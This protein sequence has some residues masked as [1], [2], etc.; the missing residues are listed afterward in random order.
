MHLREPIAYRLWDLVLVVGFPVVAFY[1]PLQLVLDHPS[2]SHRVAAEL[3]MTM[4]FGIDIAIHFR[5]PIIRRGKLIDDP[6]M[7]ARR[8]VRGRFVV[9]LLAALPLGLPF[10]PSAWQ[11]LRLLKLFRV[12]QIVH[13]WR[14]HQAPQYSTI[15]RL[16]FFGPWLPL[17]SHWLR[18]KERPVFQPLH[19]KFSG[20]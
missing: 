13:D 7:L 2:P 10:F 8:Y 9:D 3:A 5:R 1:V 20:A 17:G 18:G 19:E 11:L 14:S 15:L 12:L 6:R 16:V 4:F